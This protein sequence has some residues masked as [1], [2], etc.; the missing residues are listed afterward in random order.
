MKNAK[1]CFKKNNNP[2]KTA[3]QKF[4]LSEDIFSA[5]RNED[6]RDWQKQKLSIF[7]PV[8]RL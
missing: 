5:H 4:W 2:N 1:I 7:P 8:C 6:K 3:H